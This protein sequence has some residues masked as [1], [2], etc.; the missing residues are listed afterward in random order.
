MKKVKIKK[1]LNINSLQ[2][3]I[4]TLLLMLSLDTILCESY[5]S[6]YNRKCS[7]KL[8]SA[9]EHMLRRNRM[10]SGSRSYFDITTPYSIYNSLYNNNDNNN[11]YN[12]GELLNIDDRKRSLNIKL[13]NEIYDNRPSTLSSPS[14]SSSSST[15]SSSKK[16]RIEV[17]DLKVRLPYNMQW[18][19]VD[20]C[21]FSSYNHTLDTRLIFP[22]LTISGKITLYPIGGKCNMILRLRKAGIEF[23][24]IPLHQS[25]STSSSSLSINNE[26]KHGS[27]SAVRTDSH[28]SEPGFLSVFAHSCEGL[29]TK[30]NNYYN[31]NFDTD[32]INDAF[33]NE[34]EQLFSMGVR[35]MLTT[36]M[37]KTLQPAIK[38]TLMENMGYTL[39]YG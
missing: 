1:M 5:N 25:I 2:I 10:R 21:Q 17:S 33:T 34:L 36:Y 27:S 16:N 18:V 14:S 9:L 28:F 38:E 20:K 22:D 12:N 3:E 19:Y 29:I 23:R 24:T 13:N 32:K 31:D 37:Q 39:S 11:Y 4:I 8:E 7:T 26:S 35:G 30:Y 6:N 15:S